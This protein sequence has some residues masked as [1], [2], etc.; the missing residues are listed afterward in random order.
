[1][2]ASAYSYPNQHQLFEDL[3]EQARLHPGRSS[4]AS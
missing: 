1:M 4:A 3:E 2:V